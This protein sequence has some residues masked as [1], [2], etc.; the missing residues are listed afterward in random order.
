MRLRK[1]KNIE[2]RSSVT[3]I[4]KGMRIDAALVSGEGTLKIEGDYYGNID[5]NGDLT[6]E[7]SGY[8][9][10][11]INTDTANISGSV[12][13][14]IICT[15]WLHIKASGKIKGNITCEAI[16]MDEGAVFIGYSS[17]KD[18]LP[19]ADGSDH[20]LGFSEEDE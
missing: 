12:T 13:G 16:L 8:V 15:D 20:P 19:A 6:V 10:G 1:N 14:D 9:N 11:N 5:I 3:V 2:E 17:M 7:E 18:R 4:A